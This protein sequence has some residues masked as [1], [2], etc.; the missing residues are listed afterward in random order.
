MPKAYSYLRF[1]TPDQAKG[2]SR[3]RQEQLAEDYANK[4]GL[5][6]DESLDLRDLGKSAY[7]GEHINGGALGR[8]LEAV[9]SGRV[10]K[11]SFLLV[12]TFDRLSR[13]T[14][15]HALPQ[16]LNI[17]N[18]GITVVTLQDGAEHSVVALDTSGFSLFES[19]VKMQQA[20][21]E[22]FKKSERLKAAWVR[23]RQRA[24]TEG[25]PATSRLPQWLKLCPDT[26]SIIEIPERANLVRRIFLLSKD[27][28]GQRKI[29]DKLTKEHVPTFSGRSKHWQVSYVSKILNNRAALGEYQPH[30]TAVQED[31]SYKRIPEGEPIPNYYPAII[32][33]DLFHAAK[34]SR[35]ER[36]QSP[37]TSSGAGRK[38]PR[39][40]NLFQG[41]AVCACDAPMKY[42]NKGASPKGG[43]YYACDARHVSKHLRYATVEALVLLSLQGIDLASIVG[44]KRGALRS[45]LEALEKRLM[46][47]R[48][49]AE[50]KDKA[51][52]RLMRAIEVSNN[53]L[54][55][56]VSQLETREHE[57]AEAV[58][59]IGQLED[60]VHRVQADIES[61]E[62]SSTDFMGLLSE[63]ASGCLTLP[64]E[65]AYALRMK[66]NK[67][68]KKE[69]TRILFYPKSE[70]ATIEFCSGLRRDVLLNA[71]TGISL[72]VISSIQNVTHARKS[73]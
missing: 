13:Q 35:T 69:L 47:H 30:K 59:R 34:V 36:K 53:P 8:F 5:Q 65:D 56:L 20:H 12:E 63:V 48:D 26:G 7:K 2:D 42:V 24:A 49:E 39:Y 9:E 6:L 18:A 33:A 52:K 54:Q 45:E 72:G 68:L 44:N 37:D 41:L 43:I 27:G 71:K 66:L 16:F 58:A 15:R 14:P 57:R 11:G 62:L 32:G 40:S 22:S 10:Q 21:D 61:T 67:L 73:S 70:L 3:R 19:L 25:K 28:Y 50:E 64:D 1:S 17:I 55:S 46:A 60:E 31:G 4:R 38:G 23:K 51:I 29:A